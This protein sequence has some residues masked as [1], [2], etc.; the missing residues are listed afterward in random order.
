MSSYRVA[1]D[2]YSYS[3]KDVV[4]SDDLDPLVNRS[5][6]EQYDV[7]EKDYDDYHREV[8][9]V[10]TAYGRTYDVSPYDEDHLF[11]DDDSFNLPPIVNRQYYHDYDDQYVVDDPPMLSSYGHTVSSSGQPQLIRRTVYDSVSP[12]PPSPSPIQVIYEGDYR[13]E[14]EEIIEYVVS[15]PPAKPIVRSPLPLVP[16]RFDV[17]FSLIDADHRETPSSSSSCLR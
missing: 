10:P 5:I 15:E 3:S 16:S 11:Y 8:H 14:N 17:S 6:I 4:V 13:P 9:Y 2:Y 7:T 1:P 12:D